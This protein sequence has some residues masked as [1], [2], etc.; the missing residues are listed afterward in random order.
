MNGPTRPQT[1]ELV[2]YVARMSD[3]ELARYV[4]LAHM[5][6]DYARH[7]HLSRQARHARCIQ[8][9]TELETIARDAIGRFHA[10]AGSEPEVA[11]PDTVRCIPVDGV[12]LDDDA[13]DTERSPATF[14]G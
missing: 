3:A 7:I 6:H 1:T 4:R 5:L 13:P 8:A 12:T 11:A 2:A 9:A 14:S 10:F